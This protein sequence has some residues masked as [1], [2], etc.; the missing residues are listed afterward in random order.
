MVKKHSPLEIATSS[1]ILAALFSVPIWLV[2]MSI[3]E[4]SLTDLL[5]EISINSLI[6]AAILG[7]FCTGLAI[8]I[9]FNLIKMKS[10]IFASQSNYLIP[11]FGSFWAF[12]FLGENLSHNM[13]LGLILIV[14]G[15]WQ[16]H[17]AMK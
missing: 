7:I 5:R 15:G 3:S 4:H 2:E 12:I 11:C 8:L 10:A 9:F 14:S 1:T 16:V 6:S 17:K 13:I